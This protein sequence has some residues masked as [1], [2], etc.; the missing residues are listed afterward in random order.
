[1]IRDLNDEINKL[2]RERRHWE[3]RIVELGGPEL[4]VGFCLGERANRQQAV[5]QQSHLR[6]ARLPLLLPV[7]SRLS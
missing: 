5:P 2:L 6:L 4:G 7:P 1:M 3:K